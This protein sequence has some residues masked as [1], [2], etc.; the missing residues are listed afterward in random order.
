MY[1]E[2]LAP[3]RALLPDDLGPIREPRFVDQERAALARDDVLRLV[4]RQRRHVPDAAERTVPIAGDQPLRGILDDEQVVSIGDGHDRVHVAAHARVVDR[5]DGPRPRRDGRF[6]LRLVEVQRVR[7]DI[8]E[9][10]R[11]PPQHEGIG[12]R[13]ERERR[14]DDL[15]SGPDPTQDRG[16]LEGGRRGQAGADR[17]AAPRATRST[18]WRRRRCRP[19]ARSRAPGRCSRARVR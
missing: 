19:D 11:R 5:H 12:R 2:E 17:D 13:H 6:D 16:H 10:R 9:D 14:H 4:E 8:D 15:V 3:V 7:P 1:P 18:A